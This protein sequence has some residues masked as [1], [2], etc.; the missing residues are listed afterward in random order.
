M[1]DWHSFEKAGL[2]SWSTLLL[3]IPYQGSALERPLINIH[4]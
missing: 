3:V 1:V 4:D 2:Y